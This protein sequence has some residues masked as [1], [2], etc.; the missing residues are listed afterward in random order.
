MAAVAAVGGA[1]AQVTIYGTMDAA[2]T[3]YSSEGTS[4]TGLGNSQLGSSKLGFMGTEDLSNG[5]NAIFKLE[6]GL[7]N[8]SG[9]GKA[10]NTTNQSATGG[11][12]ASTSIGGT[13]GLVF[14]RYAYVGVNGSFG[15]LRLGRDYTN[16]FLYAVGTVD[17]FGTNGPAD[18]SALTL[19]LA[20][21]NGLA[22]SSGASNMIGYA[23]P[24]I[25]GAVLRLQAFYGENASNATN[26][27]DGNGFSTQVGYTSGPLFVSLGQQKTQGTA[28]AATTASVNTTTNAVTLATLAQNGDYAQSA[29]SASYDFGV[30]KAVFTSVREELIGA[31]TSG[32]LTST[33]TNTSNLIGLTAPVGAVNY[34]VSYVKATQ[35]TGVSGAADNKGTLWGLGLD[36]AV[37]KRT[38]LY[39]TYSSV[40][41]E[42]GSAYSAGLAG[43]ASGTSLTS[44]A[45]P[46]STGFALGVFHTF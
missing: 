23:S 41:N 12:G 25:S 6:G 32:S 28:K 46:N 17:P 13:Q 10:S 34:K 38:K 24:N 39:T 2:W 37:S 44:T 20:A 5:I 27:S 35:N 7:A 14:G 40:T 22:T 18:S 42:A 29:L 3:Q 19:N 33:S 31:A 8:D 26:S 1:S 45:N 16:T 9:N 11:A 43:G 4:K 15:E 36:Y 30:A 21:R